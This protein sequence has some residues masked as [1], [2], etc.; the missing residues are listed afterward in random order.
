MGSEMCIR[1]SPST[2]YWSRLNGL[3]AG[4]RPNVGLSPNN[5]QVD[6]GT[7]IDPPMSDPV[8]S[9]DVP[10]ASEAAEP[11]D[12]PPGVRDRFQGLSHSYLTFW[13]RPLHERHGTD[14]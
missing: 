9:A 13:V 11:P 5:P 10:E 4:L 1:D 7:R 8:Q 3:S 6:D 2:A 14:Y 12:D